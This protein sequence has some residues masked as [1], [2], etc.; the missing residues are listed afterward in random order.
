MKSPGSWEGRTGGGD[1]IRI[2]VIAGALAL[3]AT[4]PAAAVEVTGDHRL[5]RSFVEDPA[6]VQ[7]G[8]LGLRASYARQDEGRDLL[9]EVITAFR[10][11]EEIEAGLFA[12]LL[13]RR[14]DAGDLLFGTAAPRAVDGAGL[15]D[16]RVYGKY[17]LIRSPLEMS[18]GA[19]ATLPLADEDA[20]RGPGRSEYQAFVGL[21]KRFARSTWI[22]TASLTERDDAKSPGGAGGNTTGRFGTGVLVPISL[23]WVFIAEATYEGAPYGDAD[24]IADLLIGLDWRPTENTIVR[25]A[26]GGGLTDATPDFEAV[27]AAAFTF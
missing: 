18:I 16:A 9:G 13:D 1:A 5:I 6:I 14:R 7:A 2:A 3:A 15:A 17:R 22:W 25:G 4:G 11:G 10:L 19:A 21:R 20:G 23:M 26:I 8:W 12:G 27:L 24:D